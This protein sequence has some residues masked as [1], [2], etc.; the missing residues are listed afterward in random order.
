MRLAD[1]QSVVRWQV[2]A[3]PDRWPRSWAGSKGGPA[4]A[5]TSRCHVRPATMDAR[6]LRRGGGSVCNGLVWLLP[7][8][9]AAVL[10]TG[11]AV[12]LLLGTPAPC[13]MAV[14]PHVKVVCAPFPRL[15]G[16]SLRLRYA[17]AAA[18]PRA[19]AVGRDDLLDPLNVSM[20]LNQD[21]T[22]P[23]MGAS[24]AWA[25]AGRGRVGTAA[26]AGAGWAR[27]CC[28]AGSSSCLRPAA[29]WRAYAAIGDIAHLLHRKQSP[30]I[31]SPRWPSARSVTQVPC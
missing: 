8:Q 24:A 9:A 13:G 20:A 5:G 30:M 4:L 16:H 28:H 18:V 6:R 23:G 14:D 1:V 10:F 19:C 31:P 11:K 15:A 26:A 3:V 7:S 12:C 2:A 25:A 29:A 22:Q 17:R 21:S 27:Q